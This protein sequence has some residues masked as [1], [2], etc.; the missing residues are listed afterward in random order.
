M[1]NI[2]HKDSDFVLNIKHYQHKTANSRF[3]SYEA[4]VWWC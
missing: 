3:L 1:F 4:V 2:A